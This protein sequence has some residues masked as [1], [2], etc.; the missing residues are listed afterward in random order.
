MSIGRP[1][2]FDRDEALNKALD[3][4]WTH[5]Y[6]GTSLSDLCAKM[7]LSKSSLYASFGDKKQLFLSAIRVYSEGLLRDFESLRESARDPR[8]FIESLFSDLT[9]E[10]ETGCERRGCL[11]MNTAT[12]F[13]QTDLAVASIVNKTI[14]KMRVI[15][16][17]ILT[18]GRSQG[19]FRKELNPEAMS[20]FL[21]S[22]IAGMKTMVKAGRTRT[23]LEEVANLFLRLL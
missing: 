22:T 4:F 19:L 12:E 9:N 21:V 10:A 13:A 15:L 8:Q 1:I 6:R 16:E 5:G 23:E 14:E 11:V 3:Q 18:E 7:S 20:F 17:D 2:E